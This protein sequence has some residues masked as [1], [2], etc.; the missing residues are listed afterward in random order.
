M[1]I[2]KCPIGQLAKGGKK[3]IG[4]YMP[5]PVPQTIWEELSMD[6]EIA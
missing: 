1:N 4:L 6:S 3:K 5:L 2:Q